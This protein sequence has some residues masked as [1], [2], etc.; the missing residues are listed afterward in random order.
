MLYEREGELPP[1]LRLVSAMAKTVVISVNPSSTYAN[2]L[3]SVARQINT[4]RPDEMESMAVETGLVQLMFPSRDAGLGISL[5]LLALR[6]ALAFAGSYVGINWILSGTVDLGVVLGVLGC[7]VLM[8]LGFLVRPAALSM[9]VL[10]LLTSLEG[11]L[12]LWI[13]MTAGIASIAAALAGG[14]WFAADYH[15]GRRIC[16]NLRKRGEKRMM[17]YSAFRYN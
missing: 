11:D 8:L 7:S 6:V 9:G 4:G 17:G 12:T 14:G 16:R 3:A 13:G 5:T 1:S 15:A 10:I 2:A